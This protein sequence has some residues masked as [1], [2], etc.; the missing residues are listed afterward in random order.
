MLQ[1]E[2]L[3]LR[4][5]FVHGKPS[6]ERVAGAEVV[7]KRVAKLS[8]VVV[9]L[10]VLYEI[11]IL[12]IYIVVRRCGSVPRAGAPEATEPPPDNQ[13]R[14]Q[15]K[16]AALR[17]PTEAKEER[18]DNDCLFERKARFGGLKVAERKRWSQSL[19]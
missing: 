5:E 12:C 18:S 8:P 1:A 9:R 19:I 17:R 15:V 11:Y 2:E 10:L 7:A 6:W 3:D 13:L 16:L 4:K 14:Y